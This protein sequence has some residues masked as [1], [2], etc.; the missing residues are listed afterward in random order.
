M[1]KKIVTHLERCRKETCEK[2]KHYEL[3]H[4]RKQT[5]STL[6]PA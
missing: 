4:M 1:P 2:R 6:P 5:T 3:M